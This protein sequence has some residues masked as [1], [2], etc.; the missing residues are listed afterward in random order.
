MDPTGY[1]RP[2]TAS[3]AVL[4]EL[5]RR[6]IAGELHPGHQILADAI[7]RDLG[8]SRVPVREA[9]RVLEGEGQVAYHP[10]RGYFVAEL[11]I[12]DLGELYHIRDLLERD[13]LSL[14]VADLGPNEFDQMDEAL[15][16]LDAAAEAGDIIGDVRANRE[17][18]LAFIDSLHLPRLRRQIEVLYDQCDAYGSIYYTVEAN[19]TASREDH[20]ALLEAARAHDYDG[21][22]EI[23]ASHRRHVIEALSGVF[24]D[25]PSHP[26]AD[27]LHT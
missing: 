15:E 4:G 6:I 11:T 23:L 9:L 14:T 21:L 22:V 5:R 8:V 13:A 26:F 7:G 24:V 27:Q 10:H 1:K 2:P 20:L 18:H 16:D 3:T 19:R 17:F 12:A 25:E